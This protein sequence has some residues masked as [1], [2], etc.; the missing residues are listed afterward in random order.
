MLIASAVEIASRVDFD[1]LVEITSLV[2]VVSLVDVALL[3]EITSLVE[4][5]SLVETISDAAAEKE[6]NMTPDK[7]RK[8]KIPIDNFR[9]IMLSGIITQKK[10][11]INQ[12]FRNE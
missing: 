12:P 10:K 2:D 7:T 11:R 8:H 1:W 6:N 9:M 4:V 5:A 3:A